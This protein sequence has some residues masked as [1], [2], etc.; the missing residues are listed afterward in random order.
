MLLCQFF[1]CRLNGKYFN[2]AVR[3]VPLRDPLKWSVYFRCR[4]KSMLF[5]IQSSCLMTGPFICINSQLKNHCHLIMGL[6]IEFQSST[7]WSI[8]P[9]SFPESLQSMR[10]L[11]SVLRDFCV[12][13][14][15]AD[16][17][18]DCVDPD[19]CQQSSCSNKVF[20]RGAPDPLTLLQQSRSQPDSTPLSKQTFFQRVHFILGKANTHT[21]HGDM[22]FD[23][24]CVLTYKLYTNI[25][26]QSQILIVYGISS[27]L[28][29]FTVRW[30]CVQ[31]WSAWA[32]M[33]NL[34]SEY[35]RNISQ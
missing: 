15:V 7:Y 25:T 30:S 1:K 33:R 16:G 20:C 27:I 21:L 12:T 24:R 19:C 9:N 11:N 10:H 18:T 6:C 29:T 22:P 28:S 13:V 23:V 2:T 14:Y 32:G 26:H 35:F 3:T 5:S 34:V 31:R 8:V 4:K 17:L